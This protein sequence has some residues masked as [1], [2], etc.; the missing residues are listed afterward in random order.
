M[1]REKIAN[2]V[3]LH[4]VLKQWVSRASQ[5]EIFYEYLFFLTKLIVMMMMIWFWYDIM[6]SIFFLKITITITIVLKFVCTL[7]K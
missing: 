5:Q 1:I 7:L 6:I 4:I 3:L 2:K